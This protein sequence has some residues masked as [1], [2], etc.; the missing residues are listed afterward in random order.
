MTER[1]AIRLLQAMAG[2]EHGGAEAFFERLAI[3][4]HRAGVTQHILIRE[5]PRRAQRLREAG[6]H[7]AE[8]S[9]NRIV[10]WRTRAGFKQAIRQFR[11]T[12]I[13]TWM[14]RATSYCPR[15]YDIPLIAR[16]GGY[17][18]LKYYSRCDYL[19]GNTPDLVRYFQKNGWPPKRTIYLP[20]FA[21]APDA[22]GLPGG[23]LRATGRP[24]IVAMGRLH[25]NKGF[26]TLLR[27]M[28]QV[29]D[30]ELWL[31]GDGP[32]EPS[33]R[34]LAQNLPHVK[35][36]GWQDNIGA[37]LCAADLFVCPSRHE[38]LGNVIL[39]AWAHGVP[40]VAAASEGPSQLIRHGENGLLV[41]V[42]DAGALA[43]TLQQMLRD[44]SLRQRL[45]VAGHADYQQ[46]YSEPAVVRQYIDFL[47]SVP[48]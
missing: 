6:L 3:G 5:N 32:E 39:E 19:I 11:P 23:F 1:P 46:K 20:N 26:D 13:L 15:L 22:A 16:L 35:L 4:L 14:N 31:A 40:V 24:V 48:A 10:D 38:P 25:P 34:A 18:N 8:L 27:A 12:H 2:A 17:Y 29:P 37:L 21:A 45:A 47:N 41:P 36:M 28:Q 42:D 33:L 9:F 7:V 43:A 44:V 30:A